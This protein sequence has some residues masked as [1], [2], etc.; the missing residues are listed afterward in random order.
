[1]AYAQMDSLKF[2][3]CIHAVLLPRIQWTLVYILAF[4]A[5]ICTTHVYMLVVPAAAIQNSSSTPRLIQNKQQL[6][7]RIHFHETLGRD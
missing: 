4:M 7:S 2:L 6:Q 3:V 1:M 5:P